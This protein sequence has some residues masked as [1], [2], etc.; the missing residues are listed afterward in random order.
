MVSALE[1]GANAGNVVSIVLAA[2]NSVHTWWI[3]TLSCALFAWLFYGTQL[4]ADV[5][6]QV[7]F[8]LTSAL[9]WWHWQRGSGENLP[10]R[11]S[12]FTRIALYC[13]VALVSALI[14]GA[15]LWHYTQAFAPFLDSLVL[16]FSVLG[17]VLLMGRRVETWYAWIVV[18]S[19]AVPLYAVRGLEVTAALYFFFW[20]NAWY[21]L[22]RWRRELRVELVDG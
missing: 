21:G 16:A 1:I 17:Q 11:H 2:R 4:Y 9:G 6:L 12:G 19:I 13:L 5:T 14:Y 8:V 18:N 7:F 15:L 22:Y 3:G 10:I 20:C